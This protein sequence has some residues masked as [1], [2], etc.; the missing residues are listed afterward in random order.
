M[1]SIALVFALLAT[2]PAADT[3]RPAGL[4]THV[5]TADLDLSKAAHRIR[6]DRRLEAAVDEVCPASFA[7]TPKAKRLVEKCRTYAARD[8]A[9]QRAILVGLAAV[10]AA[11][12]YGAAR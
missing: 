10:P 9:R 7:Y 11:T 4:S 5:R 2:T 3:A 6:L 12:A 8:A 1:T